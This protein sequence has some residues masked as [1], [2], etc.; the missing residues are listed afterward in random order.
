MPDP[1]QSIVVDTR[2]VG[3]MN[4]LDDPAFINQG[5]VL[6]SYNHASRAGVYGTRPGYAMRYDATRAFEA[7]GLTTFTPSGQPT[8]LVK[9][10]GTIIRVSAYPFTTW[11]TLSGITLD[12]LLGPVYFETGV[13][14]LN[15]DNFGN[16][17]VL[18]AKPVLIIQTGETRAWIWDGSVVTSE[19]PGNSGT[20]IG[21]WMKWVGSRLWVAV[22][23]KLYA[24]NLLA[25][26]QFTNDG[27]TLIGAGYFSFPS[28]ITGLAV[29]PDQNTLLVFTDE[30]TSAIQANI[31][32][33]DTWLTTA[34]FQREIFQTIGCVAGRTIVTQWG[35][36]WW[37]S[38][39]GLVGLD[40][41]LTTFQSSRIHY[42][43]VEMSRSKSN[44]SDISGACS[45]AYENFLVV[46]VP[47]GDTFNSHTWVMDQGVIESIE[48]QS[49]R[50]WSSIWTGTF[51][52]Q[53]VTKMVQGKPRC[54]CLSRGHYPGDA[55][56][57]PYA[58]VWEAFT[59]LRKDITYS[60][61]GSQS[62]RDISWSLESRFLSEN[63]LFKKF[64]YIELM[65]V[66]LAYTTQIYTSFASRHS[67]FL[68]VLAK[69]LV[70][71]VANFTG[72][73]V[74]LT[75]RVR[76]TRRLRSEGNTSLLSDP[77]PYIEDK[78]ARN[79]DRGFFVLVSGTGEMAL[80]AIIL[81]ANMDEA[82]TVGRV[83][84]DETT[85]RYVQ[86]DGFGAITN[87]SPEQP[88]IGALPQSSF[89]RPISSRTVELS[90]SSL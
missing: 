18:D 25:P 16:L 76:E 89:I 67:G 17:I 3:G 49:P 5:Q 61:G 4:S 69:Q 60:S 32:D 72:D 20:P 13:K 64:G 55:T 37:M 43:D 35:M 81:A 26:D 56:N 79:K 10:L 78:Y 87:S 54:F 12:P 2:W 30:T 19:D 90:Y 77:D 70:S 29:T 1:Q 31:E 23:N 34:G 80:E 74:T 85:L 44:I 6:E 75:S 50:A 8:Y 59:S 82:E 58:D 73:P 65:F 38:Q 27:S 63:S 28:D 39:G 52:V 84:A 11:T 9:A 21:T 71:D 62:L 47:S 86:A 41:A 33:R 88:T 40:D 66:E 48:A 22:G 51:P 36:V 45:G 42:R 24:S 46:S 53:W 57:T 7:R 68:Q 14:G 15:T 83:E